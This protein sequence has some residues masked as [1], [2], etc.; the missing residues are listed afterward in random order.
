[1]EKS[2]GR[3][4]G[5]STLAEIRIRAVKSVLKGESPEVVIKS[6][7]MDRSNIYNWLNIHKKHG[8][9]GL[10]E[11]KAPGK[12]PSLNK[13]Q[14]NWIFNRI[15]NKS[16]LQL[17]FPFA[18]W[19]RDMVRQLIERQYGI[20]LSLATVGRILAKMGFS[21]QKPT[22]RA[23]Q[24][25]ETLVKQWLSKEYP[26][27]TRMAK[28]TGAEVFFGDEAAVRSDYH[29][30]KTWGIKGYTPVVK[31]TGARFGLTAV[32][33]ISPR[34]TMHFMT[35]E[36][37]YNADG[38]IQFVSRLI[39]NRKK[40]VFLIVDGHPIHKSRKLKKYVSELNGK[41]RIFY[42]PPYSPELNPDELVW[43]NL[44]NKMGRTYVAGPHQMKSKVIG[45][46]RSLQKTPAK[47][48]NFFKE[49]NVE[50]AFN[51]VD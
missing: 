37:R 17:Q 48:I 27:I 20:N 43:N 28:K 44:K 7:G 45:F 14:L 49:Q 33:A 50:Y 8:F 16:P 3:K 21:F 6:L 1:M 23:Y 25:D 40:P 47:I 18:L 34:G 32:S 46:L 10:K 29:S 12:E 15:K 19:T 9:D 42:L 22:Y 31:S 4:L 11:K 2:D 13:R 39:Y 41:L 36:G 35:V 26:Q 30:G 24:Q 38:F 51:Y 5:R